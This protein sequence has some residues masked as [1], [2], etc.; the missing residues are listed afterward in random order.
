MRALELEKIANHMKILRDMMNN[1][2]SSSEEFEL[3]QQLAE[4]C[5]KLRP[6]LFKFAADAE[7]FMFSFLYAFYSS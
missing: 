3:M 1:G 5:E 6:Q 4:T 7:G 2:A